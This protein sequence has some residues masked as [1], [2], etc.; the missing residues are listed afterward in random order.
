MTVP[1]LV[2]FLLWF[3]F[4]WR[5][6]L[7]SY[8]PWHSSQ[9]YIICYRTVL[10]ICFLPDYTTDVIS[11]FCN[12]YRS[13]PTFG[14]FLQKTFSL[15]D[16]YSLSLSKSAVVFLIHF[17]ISVDVSVA[18]GPFSTLCHTYAE[19]RLLFRKSGLGGQLLQLNVLR[20]WRN[21]YSI[22]L[23]RM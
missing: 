17:N 2:T 3:R 7:E 19:V 6:W 8:G 23:L 18:I 20:L 1:I 16:A 14:L 21:P 13:I 5:I 4:V 11:C 9:S 12:F 10:N 22:L 15:A